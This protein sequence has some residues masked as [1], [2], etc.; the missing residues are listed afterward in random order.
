MVVV[1]MVEEEP[2]EIEGVPVPIDT[3]KPNPNLE[4]VNLYL[5]MNDILHPCF[6]PEDSVCNHKTIRLQLDAFVV[7]LIGFVLGLSTVT[8]WV[9]WISHIVVGGGSLPDPK[10]VLRIICGIV[11][12]PIYQFVDSREPFSV[13][14]TS[15][16]SCYVMFPLS[17]Q[18]T[19]WIYR[20]G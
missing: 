19:C 15:A 20:C 12:L 18:H 13:P 2:S 11:V 9:E 17:P 16:S 8:R 4:F 14:S 5:D 3:S 6:H 10:Q 1:D 7:N